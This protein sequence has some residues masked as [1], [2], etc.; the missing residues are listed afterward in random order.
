MEVEQ[1]WFV[2]YQSEQLNGKSKQGSFI[3][4]DTDNLKS[5]V[6]YDVLIEYIEENKT[7]GLKVI[8]TSLNKV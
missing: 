4:V 1:E 5:S 2:S 6:L 7:N 8:L 3:F